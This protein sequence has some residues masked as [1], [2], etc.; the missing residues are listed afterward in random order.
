MMA[1]PSALPSKRSNLADRLDGPI[2]RDRV[3][4]HDASDCHSTRIF[5]VDW[6]FRDLNLLSLG[7]MSQ[8]RFPAAVGGGVIKGELGTRL[9]PDDNADVQPDPR[10]RQLNL[11]PSTPGDWVETHLDSR[12]KRRLAGRGAGSRST[13]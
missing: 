11:Q 1:R 2:Q 5:I 10:L 12:S 7:E 9:G 13:T 4:G 6:A 3:V 8:A